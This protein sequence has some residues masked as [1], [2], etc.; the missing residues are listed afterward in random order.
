M[1]SQTPTDAETAALTAV[2]AVH[3]LIA[4]AAGVAGAHRCRTQIFPS[5]V[6]RQS[7]AWLFPLLWALRVV[8]AALPVLF[9]CLLWGDR[10]RPPADG[11]PRRPWFALASGSCAVFSAYSEVRRLC[12]PSPSCCC[13]GSG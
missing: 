6:N 3:A 12:S 9:V 10:G 2:A 7:A 11:A 1:P 4:L 8:F 5:A 13:R